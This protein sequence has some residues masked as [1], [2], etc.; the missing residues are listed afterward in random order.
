MEEVNCLINYHRNKWWY[1]ISKNIWDM[2][3][4][5][6]CYVSLCKVLFKS[7]YLHYAK[8]WDLFGN[9]C[10]DGILSDY[11][12][13]NDIKLLFKNKFKIFFQWKTVMVN[14]YMILLFRMPKYIS[15]RYLENY[16]HHKCDEI[17]FFWS[18]ENF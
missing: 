16:N 4:Q 11:K 18:D 7:K 3:S 12:Q 6:W 13:L 1:Q 17:F 9:E 5:S 15:F 10:R 2:M 14:F 8:F